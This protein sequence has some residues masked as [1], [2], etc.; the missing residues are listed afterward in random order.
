[1]SYQNRA[2]S[3]QCFDVVRHLFLQ[4]VGLPYSDI[5]SE[6]T[7]QQAF[8]DNDAEFGQGEDAVYAPELT[9]WV[10]S[11]QALQRGV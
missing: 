3:V 11:T 4:A 1:M 6:E 10:F 9:L 2:G 5:L 8:A 7:I